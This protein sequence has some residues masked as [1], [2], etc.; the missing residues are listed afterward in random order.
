MR[1]RKVGGCALR[2]PWLCLLVLAALLPGVLSLH[3]DE[4]RPAQRSESSALQDSYAV[5]RRPPRL[6]TAESRLADVGP[7]GPSFS[8]RARFS[9]SELHRP[10]QH[11]S[12]QLLARPYDP[13]VETKV[14][15]DHEL[16]HA[17]TESM[18]DLSAQDIFLMALAKQSSR[19]ECH[20]RASAGH[21]CHAL[22]FPD[23]LSS[24]ACESLGR[25]RQCSGVQCIR[26]LNACKRHAPRRVLVR[27]TPTCA[28]AVHRH[29]CCQSSSQYCCTKCSVCFR[30]L[31]AMYN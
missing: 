15:R 1:R 31:F 17:V 20:E 22:Q 7:S 5:R 25:F 12:N 11:V 3:S 8:A 30:N 23:F 27:V 26:A 4:Q 10:R 24:T 13:N 18:Q 21:T 19:V 14:W 9:H 28:S 16:H 29:A 6:H 2:A